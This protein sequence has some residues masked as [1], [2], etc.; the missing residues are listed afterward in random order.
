MHEI[1]Y[2]ISSPFI[3]FF[4]I[5][6]NLYDELLLD[7]IFNRFAGKNWPRVHERNV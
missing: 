5:V 3:L 7:L 4:S 2:E 1:F 6:S